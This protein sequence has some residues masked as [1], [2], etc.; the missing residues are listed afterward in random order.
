LKRTLT[1][2]V[3]LA[4]LL[5]TGCSAGGS[6]PSA[7]PPRSAE[8]GGP[9]ESGIAVL[10]SEGGNEGSG[11]TVAACDLL[12]D[13][14]IQQ[15]LGR[16]VMEARPGLAMGTYDNGCEWFFEEDPGGLHHE[17]LVGLFA[18]GGTALYERSFLGE[19]AEANDFEAVPG[20][21][22]AALRHDKG[23][24]S[25]LQDDTI[26]QVFLFD[27]IS[28]DAEQDAAAKAL[29]QLALAAAL[30]QAPPSIAPVQS[31][32]GGSTAI[33]PCSLLT[34]EQVQ[35]ATKTAVA[36]VQPMGTTSCRWEL[37]TDSMV[38]GAHGV[39]I[40]VWAAGG[41]TRFDALSAIPRLPGVGDG[42]AML[43][44]N[45]DGNV[46]ALKDDTLLHF[47]YNLPGDTPDAQAVVVP[48]VELA[49]AAL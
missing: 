38:P 25:A 30:G 43:G 5:A 47:I 36:A 10:P 28:G 41:R 37:D 35:E 6:V 1:A 27:N 13:A 4:S 34:E 3:V 9:A 22:E 46:W 26:V 49:I 19:V 48:L 42:A 2:A 18:P 7:T 32:G 8:A 39:T 17:L 40:N 23:D 29:L 24:Y 16:T 11:A 20:I 45:T 21:G 33:D 31:P 12:T 14:D 15:V 44:G